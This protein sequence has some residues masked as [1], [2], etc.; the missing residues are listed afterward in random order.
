M[1]GSFLAETLVPRPPLLPPQRARRRIA[2]PYLCALPNLCGGTP[3]RRGVRSTQLPIFG[4]LC[5]SVA[6]W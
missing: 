1:Q 5:V 6:P 3:G 2:K 4:F